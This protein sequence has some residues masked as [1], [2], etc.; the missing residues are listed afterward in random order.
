MRLLIKGVMNRK[1]LKYKKMCCLSITLRNRQKWNHN[2]HNRKEQP[3]FP[4]VMTPC[5]F[6]KLYF[7]YFLFIPLIRIVGK[8]ISYV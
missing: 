2:M 5:H 1:T 7:H 6:S 4:Q 3:L 8:L